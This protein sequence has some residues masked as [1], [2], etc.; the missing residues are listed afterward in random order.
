MFDDAASTWWSHTASKAARGLHM[1]HA[2]RARYVVERLA[3]L[4]ARKPEARILDLGCGGGLMAEGLA[5]RFGRASVTGVDM[6]AAA[7]DAAR[8]HAAGDPALAGRLE[9]VAGSVAEAAAAGPFDAVACLEVIEHVDSGQ[10]A[11]VA[12]LLDPAVLD[13]DRG[14]VVMSTLN[15]TY[16]SY[17]MAIAAAE[18]PVFGLLPRG[19]HDWNL[20]VTPDELSQWLGDGGARVTDV[21]GIVPDEASL[22][23]DPRP[24]QWEW[25]VDGEDVDVSYILHA[26]RGEA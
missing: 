5:R 11:F 14:E 9:Y 1:I 17:A 3:P 12:D 4:L 6:S 18:M 22:F 8:A 19:T 10:A 7:V 20:F 23:P 16:K 2:A 21:S 24:T 13:P 26:R 15:R 25:R